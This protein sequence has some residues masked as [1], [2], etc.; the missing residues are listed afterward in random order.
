MH[1]LSCGV[2]YLGNKTRLTPFLLETIRELAIEPGT[3]ADPFAGTA[4]VASALK[5]AGWRVHTG[6][7]MA[8]S[9]ALQ[10]ARVELDRAPRFPDELIPESRRAP[11]SGTVSYRRLLEWLQSLPGRHGF[12]TE[13]YTPAGDA[14]KSHG[15]MYFTSDNARRLDSI[16]ERIAGW[17]S[18][19]TIGRRRSQL[20]I[21]TLLEAADRVA[22]TTGVYASFVKTWQSNARRSLELRAVRPTR[23]PNGSIGCTAYHGP[24]ERMLAERGSLDLVYLDPPYNSRQYPAYYH[25]P[26]LIAAGWSPEPEL[27]GKTGLIPDGERRSDWCRRGKAEG[28]LRELLGVADAKH[29][30]LSY[31]DEGLLP[32]P[33]IEEALRARGRSDTYRCFT[34]D[35]R[36]YRSDSDG[37][38]RTYRRDAVCEHLHYIRID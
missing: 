1:A 21:A 8:S 38:G 23:S 17:S 34:H 11:A 3:A 26:E 24:A 16:R 10:V 33:L 35:Y 19:G 30:L 29:L 5:R 27:R 2:R 18:E 20:L 36:R 6:D 14:G 32:R 7:L 22:N 25:I 31:N 9:Y 12:M 37:P 15:R 28:A 13:H 4:S